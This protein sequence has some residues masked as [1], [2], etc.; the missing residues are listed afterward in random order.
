MMKNRGYLSLAVLAIVTAVLGATVTACADSGSSDGSGF[1]G[2]SASMRWHGGMGGSMGGHMGGWFGAESS[3][4]SPIDGAREVS[5]IADEF[6]FEPN[7]LELIVGEP[8]NLTIRNDGAASHDFVVEELGVRIVVS[9][10]DE[11]TAGFVPERTGTF[12]FSCTVPGHAG[13]GMVGTLT[14]IPAN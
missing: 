1:G 9:S 10:G 13:A 8:V 7:Q 14:V 5:V 12:D 4:D 6:S 2:M 3:S 11:A